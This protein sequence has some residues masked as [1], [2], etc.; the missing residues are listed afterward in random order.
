MRVMLQ[1]LVC[2]TQEGRVGGTGDPGFPTCSPRTPVE[3]AD[4]A[5][6]AAGRRPR[7]H[8][9]PFKA[10]AEDGGRKG[11]CVGGIEICPPL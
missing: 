8:S 9:F 10:E 3:P 5:P 11:L 4:L 2:L 6:G 7:A 1:S